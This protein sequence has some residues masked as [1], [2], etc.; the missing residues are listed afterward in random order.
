MMWSARFVNFIIGS[1]LNSVK[2]LALRYLTGFAFFLPLLLATLP[3]AHSAEPV[4]TVRSNTVPEVL[5]PYRLPISFYTFEPE[6]YWA[7]P[8]DSWWM[9][10]EER[11]VGKECRSWGSREG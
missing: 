5:S 9:R 4:V 1:C 11:R 8:V 3:S 6:E 2:R 7:E 10:S